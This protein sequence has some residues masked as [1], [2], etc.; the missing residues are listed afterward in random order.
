V[1]RLGILPIW[2][3]KRQ[4]NTIIEAAQK[5]RAMGLGAENTTNMF[6]ESAKAMR[7]SDNLG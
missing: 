6:L 4:K 1:A 7:K 5:S 2:I 3:A